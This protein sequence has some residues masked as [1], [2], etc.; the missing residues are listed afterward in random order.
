MKI[1]MVADAYITPDMMQNAV[2]LHKNQFDEVEI[3]FFGLSNRKQ[4]R[5]IVR[6]IEKKDIDSIVLPTGLEAAVRHADVLMVH[7]CP[8][9]R[10]LINNAMKLKVI[11]CNRG[12]YE[13]IDVDAA[14]EMGI[15]VVTNPAHNA[16]AVAE[17]TIGL[18]L[19]ESRNIVRSHMKLTQ[20]E[21]CEVYPNTN[22]N[23]Q[24]IR[25]MIIGI[26]GFGSVGRLVVEKLQ[27]FNCEILV[28]DP[29]VNVSASDLI[30]IS[31]VSKEELLANADIISVHA[32]ADVPILSYNE[33]SLMKNTSYLIN[34]AR[35]VLV[36]TEA[37]LDALERGVIMGAAIDV[38][39]TEPNIPQ[40]IC[41]AKNITI[42]N[43][44]GGD[45]VNSYSD[46]PSM[47]LDNLTNYWTS[48]RPLRFFIN[49]NVFD[50]QGDDI[51]T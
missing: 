5:D 40:G 2:N 48:K 11:L 50:I 23:I 30:N 34:T 39:S 12:G 27:G 42:T 28:Y 31:F 10:Q 13:N 43:H 35:A 33:F 22:T 18:M 25:D 14:S 1:V 6:R 4:M 3:L 24:E 21:W 36:D 49:K 16:N 7:L 26:V 41:Q 9:T 37:L 44:R 46:S 15:K 47:M 19:C 29:F 32:R 17:Y 38:F 20:G 51:K 45:T 8:V